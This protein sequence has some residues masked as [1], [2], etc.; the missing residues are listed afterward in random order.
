MA[1]PTHFPFIHNEWVK[2]YKTIKVHNPFNNDIIAKVYLANE[3]FL[4]MAIES[5]SKGF[6]KS[7]ELSGFH[8]YDFLMKIARGLEKNQVKLS[9]TIVRES[10][11]P[12]RFAR[13][14][15]N[16]AIL[17]FTWAA[18]EARRLGGEFL[19]LDVSPQ[20]TG[21]YGINKRFPLGVILGISPFNFPLNLVAHKIAPAIASGNSMILKPASAT[22]LTALLLAEIIREAGLPEGIV[23]I[24][25]SAGKDAE[26]LV[27]DG[28]IKK[29]TFTGSPAIGWYL[30][31]IAGKKHVTLELGGNAA[32]IVEPDV[33]WKGIISRLI[34]GSFA[35]AGQ[36]CISI[37]RIYV[38]QS[39]F[40]D[41]LEKFT[42]QSRREGLYGD[43]TDENVITGPM[44]DQESA[45]KTEKW[46]AEAVKSGAKILFGGSRNK[47][48]MQ[49]TVLT[50]TSPDMR[51]I[52]EEIFAPV[53][54]IEPY[55]QFNDALLAVN[56][57][58][59]GLQA[60]VYTHD[61]RNIQRAY[62]Y[63]DVG[64]VIINDY[65]TFRVDPMPYGGTK[66]SGLGREGIRFAIE[67]MT[68]PKLL[69]IN[70][71]K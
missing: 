11:K 47:N 68:E 5:A 36:T 55:Q 64:G 39:I 29:L 6:K 7:R 23:N 38:H 46:L 28:R 58:H 69:V 41:F 44:I 52:S 62:K 59:Y 40:D 1:V 61:I 54:S 16:R 12:I 31:S 70:G 71:S 20:T 63:L 56:N 49:P 33:D 57:S 42:E 9:E 34:L 2:T 48:L 66:D 14:E 22:P 53:V 27:K 21:Y 60:G 51:V 67:E 45:K 37:Q 26:L 35:F 3:D 17:T 15:V 13:N 18:E 43:P 50:N 4:E 65:P 19:P 32:V 24:I 30:K 25:P 8:R 10:G